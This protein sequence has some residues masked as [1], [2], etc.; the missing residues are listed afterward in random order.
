[1]TKHKILPIMATAIL[2]GAMF[3]AGCEKEKDVISSK[4]NITKANVFDENNY[5]YSFEF[6]DTMVIEDIINELPDYVS[7]YCV[8]SSS[9]S[10]YTA[11]LFTPTSPDY[12]SYNHFSNQ[13][14]E[15]DG[16]SLAMLCNHDSIS[17]TNE[18]RFIKWVTKK[19]KQGK[20]V[21]IKYENGVWRGDAFVCD[22]RWQDCLC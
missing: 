13:Y 22:D 12:D 5:A 15:D 2:A 14:Y 17:T 4:N 11:E 16:E 9:N 3:F 10:L 21:I 18:G 20:Y 7:S 8:I 6:T 19:L 1:M